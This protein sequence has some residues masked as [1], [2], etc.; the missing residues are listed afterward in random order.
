MQ[1][2]YSVQGRIRVQNIVRNIVNAIL[3]DKKKCL[4]VKLK[5]FLQI[6]LNK[7]KYIG[8]KWTVLYIIKK[9]TP[10]QEKCFE[11]GFVFLRKINT[12]FNISFTKGIRRQCF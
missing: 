1:N 11:Q 4:K 2:I 3:Y 8:W 7:C 12:Y 5:F 10:V 6:N 9:N